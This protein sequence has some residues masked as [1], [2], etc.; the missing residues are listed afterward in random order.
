VGL[1]IILDY[2]NSNKKVNFLDFKQES[3]TRTLQPCLRMDPHSYLPPGVSPGSELQIAQLIVEG[4]PGDVDLAG[5][6]ED[7]R[8]DV[9]ALPVIGNDDIR[10]K[11]SIEL[12]VSTSLKK[13]AVCGLIYYNV[14]IKFQIE[15]PCVS[16]LEKNSFINFYDIFVHLLYSSRSGVQRNFG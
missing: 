11:R 5:A 16:G 3:M 8:G 12:F 6:L 2:S 14:R 9:Q 10:L 15:N 13:F 4:K 1:G 7:P